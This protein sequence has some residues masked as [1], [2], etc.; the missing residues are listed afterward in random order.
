MSRKLALFVVAVALVVTSCSGGGG[1]DATPTSGGV[2]L[3]PQGRAT[4]TVP[5]TDPVDTATTEPGP[6]TDSRADY[7]AAFAKNLTTD[8]DN[9]RL[10]DAGAAT[11]VAPKWVAAITVERLHDKGVTAAAIEGQSSMGEMS[12]LGLTLTEARG[13][14]K[15]I[16]GCGVNL[17]ERVTSQTDTTGALTPAQLD[18]MKAGFTDSLVQDLLAANLVG[19]DHATDEDV[20][21]VNTTLGELAATCN[22]A[23]G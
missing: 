23:G 13:L 5:G 2:T 12:R 11:C 19:D 16:G 6:A 9:T 17:R 7:V 15:I 10:L 4:T 3:E 18:C 8:P 22:L 21:A 14:V 1:S 20:V